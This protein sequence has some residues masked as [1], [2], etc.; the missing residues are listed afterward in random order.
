V[1]TDNN[2]L[3]YILTSAKLD[4]TRHRWL[5]E[6]T[7]FNF[8]IKYKPGV[9]NRDADGLSRMP[10]DIQNYMS[11]CTE[12]ISTEVMSAVLEGKEAERTEQVVW[13]SALSD[14]ATILTDIDLNG[15]PL[16]GKLTVSEIKSLS[17][18]TNR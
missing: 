16:H 2:P 17:S 10:L 8:D 3:T 4:S 13:I 7:D 11:R 18:A 15:S 9:N 6:L 5:V 12:S 14:N 1:F